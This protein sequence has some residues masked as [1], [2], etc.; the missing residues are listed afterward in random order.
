M[1]R[2][3]KAVQAASSDLMSNNDDTRNRQPWLTLARFAWIVIVVPSFALFVANIPTHFASL[4]RLRTPGLHVFMGQLTLVDIHT[5]QS[6]GIS[7]DFYATCMVAASLLFQ[8]SYTAMGVILFWRRSDDR[9]ALLA[10]FALLLI[11]FG[12]GYLTLQALSPTWSWLILTLSTLGNV[13]IMLCAYVFPDGRFVPHWIRWLALFM[14]G[15]WAV[16]TLLPSWPFGP[17]YFNLILFGLIASTIIVQ[18]YRYRNGSTPRQRQQTKWVVYG[19]SIAATG[20]L[21]ARLL[22]EFV[23]PRNLTVPHYLLHSRCF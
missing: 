1:K 20:N 21:S 14:L 8:F 18:V 23:V 11:P 10:S 2:T 6:W 13:S 3:G 5:L 16:D 22:Y 19:I 17:F 4:H 12:Y 9:V 15:Y 7:L